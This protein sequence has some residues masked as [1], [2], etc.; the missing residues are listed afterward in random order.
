MS[1]SKIFLF[2]I[3]TSFVAA[4][5]TRQEKKL[6]KEIAQTASVASADQAREAVRVIIQSSTHLSDKQKN[7]MIELQAKTQEKMSVINEETLKLSEILAKEYSQTNC[8]KKEIEAIKKRM[9]KNSKKR[10]EIIFQSMEKA[11]VILGHDELSS[12]GQ[13]IDSF[14]YGNFGAQRF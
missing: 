2:L 5:S 11:D 10:L 8:S 14:Y 12:R 4:C 6:E 3:L 9:V 7:E 13:V 1:Y